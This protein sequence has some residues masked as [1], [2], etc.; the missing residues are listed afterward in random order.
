MKY[1]IF[2]EYI[3]E[4]YLDNKKE[5]KYNYVHPKSSIAVCDINR[6]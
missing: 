2:Y 1:Y 3:V 5:D 6:E 4:L